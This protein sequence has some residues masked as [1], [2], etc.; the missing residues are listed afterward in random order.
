MR[1]VPGPLW[2]VLDGLNPNIALLNA[3]GTSMVLAPLDSPYVSVPI[4]DNGSLGPFAPRT[5]ALEFLDPGDLPLDY[6]VR[7]LNVTPAP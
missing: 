5:V 1:P 4:V 6:T 7:L 3:A 2:L